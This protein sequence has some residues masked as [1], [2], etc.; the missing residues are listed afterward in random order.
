MKS[1]G[2]TE[3]SRLG[4]TIEVAAA[5]VFPVVPLRWNQEVSTQLQLSQLPA[6][7][8]PAAAGGYYYPT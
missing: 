7:M 1:S 4:L 2:N 8:K 5:K 6:G 3:T